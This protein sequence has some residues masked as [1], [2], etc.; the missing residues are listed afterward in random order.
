[1]IKRAGMITGK[2]KQ[3]GT[4]QLTYWQHTCQNGR[5]EIDRPNYKI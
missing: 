3:T 5:N 4:Q 1:M 2:A